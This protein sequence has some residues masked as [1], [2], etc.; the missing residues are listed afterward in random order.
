MFLDLE[1]TGIH[2][3]V[4]AIHQISGQIVIDGETKETFNLKLRPFEGAV[5]EDEALK[6]GG[7]SK[8]DIMAY[9]DQ[10]EVFRQFIAMMAKYVNRYNKT[11]KFHLVGYNIA[12][13][14]AEFLRAF[15]KQN[16]D[17]FYGSWFWADTLDVMVLASAEL[18]EQRSSMPN[19]QQGTVA[20]RMGIVIE[21][22]KL[23]D[24][25]YDIVVCRT[26]YDKVCG[27]Y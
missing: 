19:F 12:K 14:D 4:N 6:I 20:K 7:L 10:A 1:T 5:I 18:A 16:D 26:I 17:M 3:G 27:K 2:P 9:P 13:F 15:F 23:H 11:D 25:L 8:E 22:E 21:E 24:A